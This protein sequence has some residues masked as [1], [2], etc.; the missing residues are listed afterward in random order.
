VIELVALRHGQSAANV[1]FPR[2]DAAGSEDSGLTGPDADVALTD[3]GRQQAV[4]VGRWLAGRDPLPDIVICSP[5]LRAQETARLTLAELS[6]QD[7][8]AVR[9]DERLRDRE[10]GVLEM[11]TSAAIR[12][13]HP[14]EAQRRAWMSDFLYRP[15]GGESMADVALR[16]RSFVTDALRRHHGQRVFVVG[17]DA[18]VLMLRLAIE[19]LTDTAAHAAGPVRNA[20]LTRW[21][22]RDD[23]WLELA[24]YNS[25][26]HLTAQ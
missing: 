16:V 22:G 19:D 4:A 14:D 5:Y 23:G 3:L 12:R 20:S 6:T 11:L 26:A 24:E 25:V 7:R 17:H 2:A 18:T 10:L 1:A 21:I 8:P 9:V 13:R 15:A